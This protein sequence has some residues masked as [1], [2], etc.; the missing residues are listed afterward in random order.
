MI[1]SIRGLS[2]LQGVYVAST[3]TSMSVLGSRV[4][5]TFLDLSTGV[6]REL[7]TDDHIRSDRTGHPGFPPRR[8]PP[9]GMSSRREASA[10]VQGRL[11]LERPLAATVC[12]QRRQQRERRIRET[13]DSGQVAFAVDAAAG[14][15]SELVATQV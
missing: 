14:G 1:G 2:H 8:K 9:S 11:R 15:V 4:K 3:S 10:R 12:F 6:S 7:C 5:L 13:A